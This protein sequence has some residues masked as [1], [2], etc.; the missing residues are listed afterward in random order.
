MKKIVKIGFILLLMF[1]FLS[2]NGN[3]QYSTKKVR[4]VHKQYTD[5]LKS[6]DYNYMFP[7]MGQGAYSEGF[8]IP[9][10]MGIMGNF[11][12]ADQ[13]ILINNLQ[14]GY[15][16][17]YN[18]DNSF[19][20]R[21]IVDENGEEILKFGE[22]RNV[23]YSY[24][25]RPDIWLFPFLNVYGIFGYGR[26]TTEVNITGLGDYELTA[27]LTSIVEQ[28]IKTAGVG[29]LGAG[30]VGPVW[31]SVDANFTWNKPDLLDKATMATVVGMRMGH[32]FVS[33]KRPYQNIALWV[34][35]MRIKMQS[36]TLGE[37]MMSDALPQEVWDNKDEAVT[38][39]YYWYDHEATEFQKI[40]ADRTLTPIIDELDN[41]QGESVIQYGI[42][43]QVAQMWNMLIGAQ[44][45]F[46]KH[47]QLRFETGILGDRKSF[48]AS[49]N[50][51][52]LGMKKSN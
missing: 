50:Y 24:N 35:S 43:K 12:W 21:P 14:L 45:Q 15:S 7:V 3:A 17:A 36:E 25:V 47:W 26:S 41:R 1:V 28:N 11:F 33:K 5:S 37:V 40:V 6:L 46:N 13:G 34:G 42:D 52:I 27:P 10:P 9:Y 23:S 29:V 2:E 20:L 39:Y 31:V 4:S 49:I 38:E 22:N 30:G 32:A 44:L 51:R 19:D 8:D 18:P 48:L 16:S